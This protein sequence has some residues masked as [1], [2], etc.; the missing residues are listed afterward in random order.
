MNEDPFIPLTSYKMNEVKMEIESIFVPYAEQS[1]SGPWT[2][3]VIFVRTKNQGSWYFSERYSK[4]HAEFQ[5]YK[6]IIPKEEM[7]VFPK[8]KG[9]GNRAPAF[10]EERR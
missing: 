5:N 3:Y 6:K 9:C 7:P 10:V 8:K 2:E 1:T 4:L